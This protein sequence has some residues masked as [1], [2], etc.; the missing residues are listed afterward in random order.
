ML[1]VATSRIY[2]PKMKSLYCINGHQGWLMCYAAIDLI[3]FWQT[4]SI[5][6]A[7]KVA[8]V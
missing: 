1:D 6:M 5:E 2:I 4:Q 8:R 3:G 7:I